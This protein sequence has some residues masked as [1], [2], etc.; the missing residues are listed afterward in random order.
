MVNIAAIQNWISNVVVETLMQ[1]QG[2]VG[3]GSLPALSVDL[4]LST[5]RASRLGSVRS[6]F[7]DDRMSMLSGT[8]YSSMRSQNRRAESVLSAGGMSRSAS[9]FGASSS[10]SKI[11]TTSVPLYSL[12]QDTVNLNKLDKMEKDIKSEMSDRIATYEKIKIAED[13]KRSTL[14]KKKKPKED[15][16]EEEA[17]GAD[18]FGTTTGKY[19][20]YLANSSTLLPDSTTPTPARRKIKRDYGLS[21]RLNISGI[22]RD[23]SCSID[24]WL[25]NVRPPGARSEQLDEEEEEG[26]ATVSEHANG[27][28]ARP[29]ALPDTSRRRVNDLS[30]DDDDMM[31]S[32]SG[33]CPPDTGYSNFSRDDSPPPRYQPRSYSAEDTERRVRNRREEEEEDD[34]EVNAYLSQIRQRCRERA[35]RE[36]EQGDDEVLAAWRKQEE[37][38]TSAR[39]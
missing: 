31:T 11:T 38:K 3:E 5:G 10:K 27:A 23:K 8:S 37:A 24:E 35:Q 34:D 14:F 30:D 13:N 32:M 9:E 1:K 6:G 36:M 22:E 7:D 29:S 25:K 26:A 20:S 39:S 15:S 19:G 18:A 12:F 2:D 16:D 17:E 28:F 33:Y 21:G 4:G